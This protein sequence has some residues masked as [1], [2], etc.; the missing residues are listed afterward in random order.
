MLSRWR[1]GGSPL[2]N[3]SVIPTKECSSLS[4]LYLSEST[5]RNYLSTAIGKTGARNK[6]EAAHTAQHN[7]WL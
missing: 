7:S 6:I 3:W 5:V 4:L 1:C 2:P